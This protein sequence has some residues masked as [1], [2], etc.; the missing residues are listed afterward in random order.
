MRGY[1]IILD[2]FVVL[3]A[4]GL[5][6]TDFHQLIKRDLALSLETR[7][8]LVHASGNFFEVCK[9]MWKRRSAVMTA[10]KIVQGLSKRL[11]A[12]L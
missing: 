3:D 4:V 9:R 1:A 11:S 10:E 6:K 7:F 2:G 12:E 8:L 5:Q